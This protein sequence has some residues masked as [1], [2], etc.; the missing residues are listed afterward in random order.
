[1][2]LVKAGISRLRRRRAFR[3]RS[4]RFSSII[5]TS[6]FYAVVRTLHLAPTIQ[7]EPH[8][9]GKLSPPRSPHFLPSS[10]NQNRSHHI[11]ERLARCRVLASPMSSG[12]SR[13]YPEKFERALVSANTRRR[14]SAFRFLKPCVAVE[15]SSK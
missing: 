11:L 8:P 6:C 14:R 1:M 4:K 3:Q 10:P 15:R 13:H 9:S 12:H 7:F 5:D 2:A